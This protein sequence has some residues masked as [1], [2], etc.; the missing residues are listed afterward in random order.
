MGIQL[1]KINHIKL[2]ANTDDIRILKAIRK[3]FD[4][5]ENKNKIK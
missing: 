5:H 4:D 3:I 1:E 2:I